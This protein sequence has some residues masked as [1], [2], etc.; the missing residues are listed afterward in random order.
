MNDTAATAAS[1]TAKR[2][3]ATALDDD[4]DA[5]LALDEALGA[6]LA[7]DDRDQDSVICELDRLIAVYGLE[8]IQNW[9]EDLI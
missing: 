9:T 7:W 6:C 1:P 3:R 5:C 4:I 8:A 2:A